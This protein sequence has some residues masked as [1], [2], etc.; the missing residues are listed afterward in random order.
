MLD[1][2]LPAMATFSTLSPNSDAKML[3][4]FIIGFPAMMFESFKPAI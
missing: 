3:G 4:S 1:C 2:F